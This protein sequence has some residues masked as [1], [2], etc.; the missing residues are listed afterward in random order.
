M[1]KKSILILALACV[2]MVSGGGAAAWYVMRGKPADASGVVAEAKKKPMSEKDAP[3]Y[4]SLEKVI[5]MLR[6]EGNNTEVASHYMALD[7]VFKT[8]PDKEKFTKE[9]LPLLRSLAVRTLSALSPAK[10]GAMTIDEVTAQ[11]GHAFDESY[12]TQQLDKPFMDV[13]I[14]KLIIE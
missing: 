13:M 5:V 6:H 10:A 2:L 12:A 3:K 8:A 7:L 14:G 9:Q 11:V 1:K 4:V